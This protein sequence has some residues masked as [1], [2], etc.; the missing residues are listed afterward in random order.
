MNLFR[1]TG[2]FCLAVLATLAMAATDDSPSG[3]QLLPVGDQEPEDDAKKESDVPSVQPPTEPISFTAPLTVGG[4][5][6]EGKSLAELIEGSPLFSPIKGLPDA[7]WKGKKCS[8]C[9]KWTAQALCTQGGTYLKENTAWA[10][11][12]EHPLGGGL[13]LNLKFWAEQQCK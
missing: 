9:H 10:L 13:K 5:A 8:A 12:K 11:G 4:P 7:V 6:V 3:L 2:A 1:L